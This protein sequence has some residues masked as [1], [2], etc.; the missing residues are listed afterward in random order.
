MGYFSNFNP[1]VVDFSQF[2]EESKRYLVADI[3]TNARFKQQLLSNFLY[4]D[5]YDIRGNET[6]EILSEI[7]YGTPDLHWLIML[8]NERYDYIND[9]PM[10]QTTI[11]DYITAKYGEANI[12]SIHHY[13]STDGYV[14][15]SDYINPSGIAD[16]TPITN[17]DYEIIVN[18]S[19]RRIKVIPPEY[20]GELLTKFR[21]I[22]KT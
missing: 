21:E 9:F 10:D 14:V 18:E 8:A 2:G 7:F 16:A 19:K 11:E 1:I 15:N 4:Y 13:E 22:F 6:P 3:I 5:E 20:V 17:Y 12:Y